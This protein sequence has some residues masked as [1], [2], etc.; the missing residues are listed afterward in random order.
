MALRFL[1]FS[2]SSRSASCLSID[3]KNLRLWNAMKPI[4]FPGAVFAAGN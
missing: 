4:A 3:F 1:F 2:T